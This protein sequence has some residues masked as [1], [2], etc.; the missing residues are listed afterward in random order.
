MG[1]DINTAARE[2]GR[3]ISSRGLVLF[4]GAGFSAPRAQSTRSSVSGKG[5]QT[6]QNVSRENLDTVS[7]ETGRN[8]RVSLFR[9]ISVFP[10]QLIVTTNFDDLLERS[11]LEVGKN[12]SVVVTPWD[13]QTA[14]RSDS[15]VIIVKLHGDASVPSST[16]LTETDYQL[17]AE[18]TTRLLRRVGELYPSE[19]RLFVGFEPSDPKLKPLV[20]PKTAMD[21]P[22]PKVFLNTFGSPVPNAFSSRF[23]RVIDL[24]IGSSQSFIEK[25]ISKTELA[26]TGTGLVHSCLNSYKKFLRQVTR[27]GWTIDRNVSLIVEK[28]PMRVRLHSTS[29]GILPSA[30]IF[31]LEPQKPSWHLLNELDA[32]KTVLILGPPGSGKTTLLKGL[33]RRLVTAQAPPSYFPIFL[34]AGDLSGVKIT[35][36]KSL[37][38]RVEQRTGILGLGS[39]FESLLER[40]KC[41]LIID[42]L[43]EIDPV[44]LNPL[45]GAVKDLRALFPKSRSIC[46]ARESGFWQNSLNFPADLSVHICPLR[47]SDVKKFIRG[48]FSDPADSTGLNDV[49]EQ[50]KSL[51]ELVRRPLFLTLLAYVWNKSSLAPVNI[52]ELYKRAVELL[53]G[54]WDINRGIFRTQRFPRSMQSD[55]LSWCGAEFVARSSHSLT[56]EEL[57]DCLKTNAI[58]EDS[59][60]TDLLSV[61]EDSELVSCLLN[62]V[63]LDQW[64][65]VHQAFAEYFA[66][67]FLL[68]A[69]QGVV[70]SKIAKSRSQASW[71]PVIKLA[72]SSDK[73]AKER[74]A[75]VL[76]DIPS[77][78]KYLAESPFEANQSRSRKSSKS[79]P[80]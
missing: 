78:K 6:T 72:L 67:I 13:F 1:S 37:L 4:V 71:I 26:R 9:N 32:H 60:T 47:D 31:D 51:R 58:T 20:E 56:T 34:Q 11:L 45:L 69:E 15:D 49:L 5:V 80:Q 28:A 64:A 62:R 12:V 17:H 40:E 68:S 35:S 57:I 53:L 55:V 48:W 52:W 59:S 74:L 46:A 39:S 10:T 7:H 19:L 29:L 27:F 44:N 73:K 41:V 24:P 36:H 3:E 2:I 54:E 77:L 23:S 61:L 33:I 14:L 66:A 16:T 25:M 30:Q 43:D 70:T 21:E 18:L 76:S 75:Q 42:G 65:F 50:N 38:D 79:K 63:S 22:P 8:D